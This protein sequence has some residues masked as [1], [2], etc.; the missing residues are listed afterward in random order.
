MASG[1][2]TDSGGPTSEPRSAPLP[3]PLDELLRALRDRAMGTLLAG[4]PGP[5][6][7]IAQIEAVDASP[8]VEAA[9]W[10]FVDDL[11]RAHALVQDLNTPTGSFLH[12]I[13]HRREGD[14]SNSKYWFRRAGRHLA[15]DRLP[16]YDP[17]AFVDAVEAARGDNPAALIETQRLEWWAAFEAARE[18]AS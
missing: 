17:Y 16:A 15:I 14:F 8:A 11:E 18:E 4:S 3:A 12:A 1:R 13:L 6:E 2:A 7:A 5:P 10:L 9:L